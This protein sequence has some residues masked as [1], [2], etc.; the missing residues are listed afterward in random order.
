MPSGHVR[1][2]HPPRVEA[3]QEQ[4]PGIIQIGPPIQ[5]QL[6]DSPQSIGTDRPLAGLGHPGINLRKRVLPRRRAKL[7]LDRFA[8]GRTQV[9]EVEGGGVGAEAAGQQVVL[10]PLHEAALHLT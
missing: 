7:G 6:P 1:E 5:V 9:A 2:R 4:V 8:V 10:V 3:Q